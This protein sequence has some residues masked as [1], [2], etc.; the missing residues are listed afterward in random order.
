MAQA[1][2][3]REHKGFRRRINRFARS[4]HF[5]GYRRTEENFS[6]ALPDH[7]ANDVLCQLNSARAVQLDHLHFGVEIGF[8]KQAAY[9][10]TGVQACYL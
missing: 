4:H 8:P 7:V 6:P 10:N 2:G 9:S 1:V 3:E 5:T